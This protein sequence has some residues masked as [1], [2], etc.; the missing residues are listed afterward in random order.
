[1]DFDLAGL[2][3]I[4][5][6]V[7]RFSRPSSIHFLPGPDVVVMVRSSMGALIGGCRM[8]VLVGGPLHSAST[9]LTTTFIAMEN[10]NCDE[11]AGYSAF[12]SLIPV[13]Y[14]QPRSNPQPELE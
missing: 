6:Q 8:P 11:A 1:M 5:A 7:M 13:R 2:K 10:N 12:L 4:L 9:D 14:C 3:F